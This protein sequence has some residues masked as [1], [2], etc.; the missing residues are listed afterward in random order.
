M[1]KLNTIPKQD[2][3]RMPAE[4]EKHAGTW[5]IWPERPDNWRLGGKP[6]QTVFT[7]VASVIGK[8]EAVTV[9]F[10]SLPKYLQI[11]LEVASPIFGIPS[12][13]IKLYNLTFLA[14]STACTIL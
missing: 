4:F 6:A 5:I 8:Y 1:K 11:S 14:F 13:Y 12:A 9:A 7:E 3:F 2:G 10:M